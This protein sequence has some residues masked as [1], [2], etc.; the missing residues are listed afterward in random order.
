MIAPSKQAFVPFVSV[1]N[2]MRLV[3]AI[4]VEQVMVDLA[5]E[6]EA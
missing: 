1:A 3:H 2:M 4:G 6:I 5:A